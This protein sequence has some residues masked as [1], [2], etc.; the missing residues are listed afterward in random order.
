[1]SAF[2]LR[3]TCS[4]RFSRCQNPPKSNVCEDAEAGMNASIISGKKQGSEG[5]GPLGPG[6]PPPPLS[7]ALLAGAAGFSCVIYRGRSPREQEPWIRRGLAG[8]ARGNIASPSPPVPWEARP[9]R[10]D[11][12]GGRPVSKAPSRPGGSPEEGLGTRPSARGWREG[13]LWGWASRGAP[14]VSICMEPADETAQLLLFGQFYFW[15]WF[16]LPSVN[17]PPWPQE[18]SLQFEGLGDTT[19]ETSYF[20]RFLR[21]LCNSALLRQGLVSS[22]LNFE[23]QTEYY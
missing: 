6:S 18:A 10:G 7:G 4:D 5:S 17:K 15:S 21:A 20:R 9:V 3:A 8:P 22:L 14:D 1:M 16:L 11:A 13:R 19:F 12:A 2:L 23:K